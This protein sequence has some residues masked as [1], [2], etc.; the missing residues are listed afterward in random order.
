M[1]GKITVS[2]FSE[3][4]LDINIVPNDNPN[5]VP[6]ASGYLTPTQ[7]SGFTVSGYSSYQVVFFASGTDAVISAKNV[8]PN[9]IVEIAITNE[10]ET[11]AKQ[12]DSE[13]E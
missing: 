9:A 5:A 13:K 8:I 4:P 2:N 6:V 10:A 3:T 12:K 1:S 11:E 7:T